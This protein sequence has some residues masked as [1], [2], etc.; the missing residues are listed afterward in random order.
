MR[1]AGNTYSQI[2]GKLGYIS[3]GTL[4]SWLGNLELS[5]KSKE[6]LQRTQSAH[7]E[8]ARKIAFTKIAEKREELLNRIKD[9]VAPLKSKVNDN[10][11]LKIALAFLYLGEGSKWKSHRGLQLG[12]SD[13]LLLNLYIKLL[14]QCYGI[15]K[16]S[17]QCYISYRADQ[18]LESLKKFWSKQLSIPL[19]NFHN[20][21]SDKRTIGKPTKNPGYKGVC[22]ISGGST[23][24]QQE[25]EFIPKIIEAGR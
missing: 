23:K 5:E 14:K 4:N 18:N 15:D 6:K 24:I 2:Q 1:R 20:S 12:S 22:I 21:K 17:L 8:K 7:L 19:K 25:L 16:L 13:P 3:K 9:G 11:T 10:K